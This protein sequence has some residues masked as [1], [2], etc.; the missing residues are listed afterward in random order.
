MTQSH[1]A[2]NMKS[3]TL[4]IDE[5]RVDHTLLKSVNNIRTCSHMQSLS[6]W[7]PPF[8]VHSRWPSNSIANNED[9]ELIASE[10]VVVVVCCVLACVCCVT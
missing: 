8:S 4:G 9:E 1:N 10:R 6:S 7:C 2:E 5:H 3:H